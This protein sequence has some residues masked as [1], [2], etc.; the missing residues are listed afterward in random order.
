MSMFTSAICGGSTLISLATQ[1]NKILFFDR[2]SILPAKIYGCFSGMRKTQFFLVEKQQK[3][4]KNRRF[5]APNLTFQTT[6]LTFTPVDIDENMGTARMY[7]RIVRRI[8]NLLALLRGWRS[9][10][11]LIY[12]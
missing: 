7:G 5:Q 9:L 1:K 12:V 6:Q 2:I 11:S 8:K 3:M 10:G 4:A